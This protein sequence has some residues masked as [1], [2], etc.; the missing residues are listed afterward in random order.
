[1]KRTQAAFTLMELMVALTVMAIL[2]G[3][4][5]PSFREFTRNNRVTAAH[6]DLATAF[7]LARSESL[8]R[9]L[10][11]SVCATTDGE[12]CGTAANWTSGW[13][14]FVDNDGTPGTVDD[15]DEVVQLWPAI[16]GDVVIAADEAFVQ[17]VPSGTVVPDSTS[18]F[19][20]YTSGCS[21]SRAQRLAISAT[22]SL[23]AMKHAC[24]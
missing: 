22:G 19:D 15:D 10:P 12:D 16:E 17:Y 6:N 20:V 23:S 13:M 21:G 11:V 9:S 24:P 7:T 3:F 2:V 14:V 4:A 5:V 1:M 18:I 8:K